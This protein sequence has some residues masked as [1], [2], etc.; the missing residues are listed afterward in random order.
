[1]QLLRYACVAV[2]LL[3]LSGCATLSPD[4]E[5]P[6]VRLVSVQPVSAE[7][8]LPEFLV[9]LRVVNPNPDALKLRGMS[10]T[11]FLDDYDIVTGAT[12][13]LPEVP[14][15]GEADI[16]IQAVVDLVDAIRFINTLMSKSPSE[17]EYRLQAK[18]DIGPLLPAI[19][20]EESGRLGPAT[21]S[22]QARDQ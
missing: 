15:Y 8:M 4:F 5:Q 14:A 11:F 18:L 7:G 3:A 19:R 17:V 13:D 2:A 16:D 6:S 20:F 9:R 10:Y 12:S 22:P 21:E 1:M